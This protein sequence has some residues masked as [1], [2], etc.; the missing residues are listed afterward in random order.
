MPLSVA[1]APGTIVH[2]ARGDRYYGAI[3]IEDQLRPG[4]AA[5]VKALEEMLLTED[6][7]MPATL[8]YQLG[9]AMSMASAAST[10]FIPA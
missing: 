1:S 2:V 3:T 8:P 9:T 10:A 6:K 7:V 5:A 4:A